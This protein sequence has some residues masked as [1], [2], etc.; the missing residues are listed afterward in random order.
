MKLSCSTGRGEEKADVLLDLSDQTKDDIRILEEH[1][2]T[3]QALEVELSSYK[4]SNVQIVQNEIDHYEAQQKQAQN[5]LK[6]IQKTLKKLYTK[7][8]NN[9]QK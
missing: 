8:K 6:K 9:T 7:L 3:I 4:K 1:D 2:T 5:E